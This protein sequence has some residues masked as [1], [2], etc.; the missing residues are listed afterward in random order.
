MISCPI[1]FTLFDEEDDCPTCGYFAHRTR[2]NLYDRYEKLCSEN[3]RLR[4][5]LCNL[6]RELDNLLEYGD[7]GLSPYKYADNLI[8]R[9][10]AIIA[11]SLESDT[12]K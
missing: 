9:L 8:L 5:G 4:D 2:R 11:E 1:C 12:P 6:D 10:K 3:A 7:E